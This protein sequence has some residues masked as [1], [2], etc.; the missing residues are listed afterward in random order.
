MFSEG[1]PFVKTT[2]LSAKV[3]SNSVLPITVSPF[4]VR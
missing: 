3:M 4:T 1:F 2:P